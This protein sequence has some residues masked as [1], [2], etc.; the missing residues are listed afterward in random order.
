MASAAKALGSTALQAAEVVRQHPKSEVLPNFLATKLGIERWHAVSLLKELAEA[1]YGT[2]VVGRRGAETR[3]VKSDQLPI[4]PQPNVSAIDD[5]PS[6][7]DKQVFL[8]RRQPRTVIE[9][10]ADI[11][12]DEATVLGKWLTLIANT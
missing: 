11:T 7:H 4:D 12:V 6:N 9:V 8:L 10:P 3:L 2:Y 5:V 1:G